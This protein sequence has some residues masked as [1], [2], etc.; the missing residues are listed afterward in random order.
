MP[1]YGYIRVQEQYDR[2]EPPLPLCIDCLTD[3]VESHAEDVAEKILANG[4]F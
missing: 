4:Y 2:Q 1:D 3:W